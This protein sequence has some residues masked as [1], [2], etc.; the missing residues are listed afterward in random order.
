M[1]NWSAHFVFDPE[2]EWKTLEK[3]FPSVWE[4]VEKES[5]GNQ[6][7]MQSDQL[8]LEL[9]LDEIRNNRK[10]IGFIRD[11]SRVRLVFPADR[12]EMILFRGIPS[13]TIRELAEQISK[14]LKGKKVKFSV[15]YDNMLLQ[16]IKSRKR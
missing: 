2:F 9:N 10:P 6:E 3:A 7:D 11:G 14:V 8:Y 16:E 5:K 4:I 1:K 12:K 13:D 15:S